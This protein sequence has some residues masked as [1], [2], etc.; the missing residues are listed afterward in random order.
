MTAFPRTAILRP[1]LE[2]SRT[3]GGLVGVVVGDD[4][5]QLAVKKT[6]K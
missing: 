1:L 3:L 5:K 4:L 6:E 2:V